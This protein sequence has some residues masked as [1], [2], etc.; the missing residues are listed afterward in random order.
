MNKS[1][2]L[3][4]FMLICCM[5]ALALPALGVSGAQAAEGDVVLHPP[6]TASG[7]QG[8]AMSWISRISD[9]GRYVAFQ[10]SAGNLIPGSSLH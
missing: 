7:V 6:A 2:S 1:S 5:L 10:T 3:V 9:D 4:R 8:D